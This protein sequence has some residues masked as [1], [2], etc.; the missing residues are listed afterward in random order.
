MIDLDRLPVEIR[1]SARAVLWNREV[2]NGKPTKVP[3]VPHRP[4]ELAAVD[5]PAT[6]DTFAGAHAAY[7]E[8]KADGVG[9][10]L[11]DGL[12][13]VDL[14]DCRDP[15][16]GAITGGAQGVIQALNSYT[17]ASPSG[18]GIHIL[19][20]GTLPPGR[21][22]KGK[23]EMY[24]EGRYFTVTGQ[25][26][27]GTPP[28]IE[29][30]T[31][32]LAA[33][34]A[35]LF[36]SNSRGQRKSPPA[37][38]IPD[39]DAT[40]LERARQARN[41]EAFAR[42]WAGDISGYPSHSEADL[43]VC[44]CL[45]FW[46]GKNAAR[47][48]ALFR[49]SNLMREKWDERHG[50]QTYGEMTI[51]RAIASCEETYTGPPHEGGSVTVEH[52]TDLGN[53]RRLVARHGQGLRRCHPWGMWLAWDGRRWQRDDSG[54]V[55]R[56]GKDVVR[57]IY[58]EA[59]ACADEEQ[60]KA[61]AKHAAKC[62]ADGKVRAMLSMAESEPEL[63]VRP[64]DF[65]RNP[66]LLTV[67][68]GTI[69]LRTGML[70]AHQHEDLITKLAPVISDPE[71]TAPTWERFLRR[72]FADNLEMIAF[73]QRAV[74]YS[75]TGSTREQ[76]WFLLH[77]PGA[78][79]KTTF[80]RVM[81]DLLGEYAAWTPTQTLLAKRGEHVENDLARLR[82]ARLVAAVEAEGGRRL[83]EALVK[84]LTG[85]DA[86]TARFLYGEY[87]EFVPTFKLW[88]GT[89]HKP[90]IRGTDHA[91][92]RR[93]RLIP[94]TVT[95]PEAEQD[96]ELPEKLRTEFPGILSWAVQGCLQWQQQGLGVPEPVRKATADYREAMDI[97]GA[98]LDE[99]CAVDPEARAGATDLYQAYV[100]WCEE[101]KE[102]PESQQRFGEA[103]TER[104]YPVD[105]KRH[106]VTKRKL[107]LGLRLLSEPAEK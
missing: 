8:G 38:A 95:I 89:N 7:L 48:D 25:H 99:C 91:V 16:T 62:E 80:L 74:G 10:V 97:I 5:D 2:R 15:Q 21:R 103:L 88:F 36:G 81:T 39:D 79:G 101:G 54:E 12:A 67:G 98:F 24:C 50:A 13:G 102:R 64:E 34:H 52:L 105:P 47:M 32:Q 94:F 33:L 41:G 44:N 30:R 83:A 43:A 59:S 71:A 100:K 106:P 76:A 20:K 23:I 3:Y 90:E 46:T 28:T 18:K 68:N 87:F 35:K 29:E 49:Q 93:I 73:L 66:W 51:A 63:V 26:L 53:A 107:R 96:R 84:Q 85:G 92:W 6:W 78:N 61:L 19:V 17:E 70:R 86:V 57:A 4:T 60:R 1:H 42:L 75:L 11:G 58:A 56:R 14:D 45:A 65:D 27:D 9:V 22:R 37:P 72:I 40:L 77:G 82:G 55:F 69:D 104:G 31:A